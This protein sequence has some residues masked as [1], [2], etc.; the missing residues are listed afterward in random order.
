MNEFEIESDRKKSFR[1]KRAESKD[2]VGFN[3]SLNLKKSKGKKKSKKGNKNKL[4][5]KVAAKE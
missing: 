2:S 1:K 5:K 4:K 3:S